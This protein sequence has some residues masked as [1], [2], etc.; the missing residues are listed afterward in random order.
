MKTLA[1]AL[2]LASFALLAA[3]GGRPSAPS[4]AP[5][6]LPSA[7][8][9]LAP[10]VYMQVVGE[11]ALF[12]VKA[13]EAAQRCA[14]SATRADARQII[15]DQTGVAAQLSFAGRRLNLLPGATLGPAHA[16]DLARLQASGDCDR[17]YR[18]LVGTA[19]DQ[20]FEAHRNFARSGSSPTLRPVADMAAPVTRRNVDLLRD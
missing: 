19:L 17:D 18:R 6:V 2:P 1:R 20:A 13:S 3:C 9:A 4:P 8:A 12:A 5:F 7:A 14:A 16:A 15:A 10:A 11:A